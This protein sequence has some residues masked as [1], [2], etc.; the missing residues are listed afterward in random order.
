M[1]HIRSTLALERGRVGAEG[2]ARLQQGEK[3]RS[4]SVLVYLISPGR[5]FFA[6]QLPHLYH[7]QGSHHV[8][9]GIVGESWRKDDTAGRGRVEVEGQAHMQ[10]AE[11]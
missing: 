8:C 5:S 6:P 3:G 4:S 7:E 1:C 11:N 9:L 2:T 10:Q